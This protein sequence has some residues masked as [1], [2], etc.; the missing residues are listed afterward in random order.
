MAKNYAS[1]YSSTNDSSALEQ[2]IYIKVETTRGEL[3][4]PAGTDFCYTLPGSIEFSQP[5][6][7][8]PHRSGR[9]N[10]DIIK[11]KKELSWTLPLMF[12]IDES[13]GAADAAEI[14][15][16]VRLLYKSAL[17]K[18]DA[19]AGAV[20]TAAEDPSVTFS[21]FEC[22]DKWGKQ[23]RGCFVDGLTLTFPGDG[24]SQAEFSGMG[25][26]AFL[27]GIGKST[28]NNTTNTVTLQ[29]GEGKRFPVGARV[30]IVKSDGLTRSSDTPSGS[31]R[32]VT[33]V[34]GDAVTLSGAALTDA[35]GSSN[36]VYLCYYEPATKS[37]INNP[38]TGLKGS[39]EI[40][41]MPH[42][43][44][45][46]CTVTI[47]NAHEPVNY[48]FGK[49]ALGGSIFVPASRMTATLSMEINMS[50]K[51]VEFYN[52]VQAFEP[53][54]ITL[55]LGDS[56]GRHLEVAMPKVVFAIPP[57]SVPESGSIPVTFEGNCYQTS[58]DAADE[59]TLSFI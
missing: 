15:S 5:V 4:T 39:I 16:P 47:A 35:D 19:T 33:S 54:D 13:L 30:M 21:I 29:S 37:G 42:F 45:R 3:V 6:E 36:P 59:L 51:L 23:A 20:F 38:V 34:V 49:D 9:H 48:C 8:S 57:V 58:L 40:D 10:T 12:N 52:N 27:V 26:E 41:G 11:S 14:D 25:A 46:S 53:Q 31:S 32:L 44:V 43:C 50:N 7:S 56:A 2:S 22:G 1:Y 18:E 24:N 28:A 55:I 17:G